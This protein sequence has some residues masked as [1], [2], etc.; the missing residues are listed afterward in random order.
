MCGK[1]DQEKLNKSSP[2]RPN[3]QQILRYLNGEMSSREE[4][5]LEK[6]ALHDP[7][8]MEA[9][10]G[11]ATREPA[12]IRSELESLEKQVRSNKPFVWIYRIAAAVVLLTST[13]LILY[14]LNI[15]REDRSLAQKLEK[16]V[17]P[18]ETEEVEKQKVATPQIQEQEKEVIDKSQNAPIP[19][20]APEQPI[21]EHDTKKE[22]GNDSDEELLAP[23]AIPKEEVVESE[24]PVISEFAEERNVTLEEVV[25]EETPDIETDDMAIPEPEDFFAARSSAS[26]APGKKSRAISS[27]TELPGFVLSKEHHPLDSVEVSFENDSKIESILTNDAGYFELQLPDLP[28]EIYFRKS[29]YSD[30]SVLVTDWEE[31]RI[32][33]QRVD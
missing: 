26:Q 32:I 29:G 16:E 4:Y 1:P 21:R 14:L 25:L 10:E 28:T 30:T 3:T 33:L 23:P 12:D 24:I 22:N 9:L 6:A 7:F 17:S 20:L 27:A 2:N 18:A 8:L 19:E 11:L 5:E 13:F 31:I 15:D